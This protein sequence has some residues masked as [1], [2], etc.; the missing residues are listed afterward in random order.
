MPNENHP[1]AKTDDGHLLVFD[2]LVIDHQSALYAFI[3]SMI[4]NP[5]DAR[6]TVQDVNIVLYRKKKSFILGTNFKAWAFTIARFE[7]LSYLTR[8]KKR[9]WVALD[10]GLLESLADMAEEET[11]DIQPMLIAMRQ[12]LQLLPEEA[13]DLIQQRYKQKISMESTAMEKNLSVPA[14]KQKLYRVRN[15]LRKCILLR[16][17]ERTENEKKSDI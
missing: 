14:L 12:C 4:F 16:L 17:E 13:Q 5:Q 15:R 3:R 2:K 7:C 10:A 6:D 1:I 8:Y 11:D 9:T